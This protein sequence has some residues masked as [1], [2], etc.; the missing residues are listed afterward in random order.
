M[1]TAILK[2][3]LSGETVVVTSAKARKGRKGAVVDVWIDSG[4]NP[5]CL[6]GNEAPDWI[7]LAVNNQPVDSR[8]VDAPDMPMGSLSR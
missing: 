1:S 5:V 7:T 4:K 3:V 6:V 8:D 2:N